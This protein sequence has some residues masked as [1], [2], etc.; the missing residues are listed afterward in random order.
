LINS[1]TMALPFYKNS[2]LSDIVFSA[3]LF[4]G[5]EMAKV[6]LPQPKKQ[7]VLN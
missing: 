7:I 4:G 1:Y 2:L 6:F 3:V 5:F